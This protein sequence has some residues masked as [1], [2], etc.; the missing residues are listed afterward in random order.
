MMATINIVTFFSVHLRIINL[1]STITT[2]IFQ[3]NMK[4]DF[5]SVSYV[6]YLFIRPLYIIRLE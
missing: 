2:M 5:K 1:K 3:I 4:V 6:K